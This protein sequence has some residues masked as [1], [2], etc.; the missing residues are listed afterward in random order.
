MPSNKNSETEHHVLDAPLVKAAIEILPSKS[1]NAPKGLI[2]KAR[3]ELQFIRGRGA[4]EISIVTSIP[5]LF[6]VIYGSINPTTFAFLDSHNL[7]GVIFQAVPVLAILSIA[8]GVLM[9]AGEYDLSLGPALTLNAIVFIQ[10]SNNS[11]L[12]LGIAAVLASGIAVALVNG[13]IVVFAK[14]PSF[15]ATLGMSFF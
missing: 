12:W 15:I 3:H 7:S 14:I 6:Y 2:A 4:F 5:V 11:H 8:S 9:V 1:A 13:L 10:V